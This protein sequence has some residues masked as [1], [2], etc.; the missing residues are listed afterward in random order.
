MERKANITKSEPKL[1]S[2][3]EIFPNPNNGHQV[4]LNFRFK[5]KGQVNF[6]LYNSTG[7]LI[8]SSLLK[9]KDASTPSTSVL[10]LNNRFLSSGLYYI[11]LRND[12]GETLSQK[13]I[14]NN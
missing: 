6:S 5:E 3:L 10:N 7:I 12:K 11:Q 13:L 1:E 9:I 4:V 14:I 2:R 8:E